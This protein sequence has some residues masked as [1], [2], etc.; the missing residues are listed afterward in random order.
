MRLCCSRLATRAQIKLV[1]NC[2]VQWPNAYVV[3]SVSLQ[4]LSICEVLTPCCD[5]IQLPGPTN[6]YIPS[7]SRLTHFCPLQIVNTAQFQ[8]SILGAHDRRSALPKRQTRLSGDRCL[9]SGI[10]WS[11]EQLV[12]TALSLYSPGSEKQYPEYWA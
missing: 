10:V 8:E 4:S 6:K 3:R 9:M 12:G 2:K 5:R 1:N 11:D 7:L